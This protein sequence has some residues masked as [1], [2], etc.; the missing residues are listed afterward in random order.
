M[1]T[2]TLSLDES[3]HECNWTDKMT[4]VGNGRRIPFKNI[5]PFGP[6]PSMA[7]NKFLGDIIVQRILEAGLAHIEV[8][9][10]DV[11]D[12]PAF[13]GWKVMECGRKYGLGTPQRFYL[14]CINDIGAFHW[15][16]GDGFEV[17][18]G[19]AASETLPANLVEVAKII[20]ALA[21]IAPAQVVADTVVAFVKY[22]ES[23][24]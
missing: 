2:R 22:K 20:N 3:L 10:P 6:R 8:Q 11:F 19:I 16:A 5:K 9:E 15:T 12:D 4:L 21:E 1:K 17:N 14:Y 23:Q 7:P 24:S 13:A 18:V